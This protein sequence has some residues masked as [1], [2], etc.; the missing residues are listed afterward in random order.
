M[1]FA[2]NRSR[3]APQAMPPAIV[4]ANTSSISTAESHMPGRI[5]ARIDHRPRWR[6]GIC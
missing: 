1:T 2:F 3:E 4:G 6:P 5:R